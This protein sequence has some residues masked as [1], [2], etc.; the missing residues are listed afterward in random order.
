M[1]CDWP[2]VGHII[3]IN[4]CMRCAAPSPSEK[5]RTPVVDRDEVARTSQRIDPGWLTGLG[6]RVSFRIIWRK[7]FGAIWHAESLREPALSECAVI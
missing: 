7:T 2:V 1:L 6:E 3:E 4:P 5:G